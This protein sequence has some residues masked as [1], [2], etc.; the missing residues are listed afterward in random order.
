MNSKIHPP[1]VIS[2]PSKRDRFKIVRCKFPEVLILEIQIAN[3]EWGC[4]VYV[5]D[6]ENRP[7]AFNDR[8]RQ[9]APHK[10]ALWMDDVPIPHRAYYI[11]TQLEFNRAIR[12]ER[13][14]DGREGYGYQLLLKLAK[15]LRIEIEE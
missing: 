11:R 2:H 12:E 14:K 15:T 4:G 8:H 9:L 1:F 5:T 3:E 7:V 6:G 13:N 10:V